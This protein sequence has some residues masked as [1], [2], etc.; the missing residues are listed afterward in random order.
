MCIINDLICI[1]RIHLKLTFVFDSRNQ[2]IIINITV[3]VKNSVIEVNA[4]KNKNSHKKFYLPCSVS[5]Y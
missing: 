3:H 1:P 5:L 2:T 4:D